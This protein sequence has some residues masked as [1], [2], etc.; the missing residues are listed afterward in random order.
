LE[1]EGLAK[2]QG[3]VHSKVTSTLL[4]R[5]ERKV[6]RLDYDGVDV[7]VRAC[8]VWGGGFH[9][10]RQFKDDW[11]AIA[12]ARFWS[13]CDV[14]VRTRTLCDCSERVPNGGGVEMMIH[15]SWC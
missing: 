7:H 5:L 11:H 15:C 14:H 1:V 9:H 12:W 3:I 4:V 13:R 2:V 10:S 6:H 8:W